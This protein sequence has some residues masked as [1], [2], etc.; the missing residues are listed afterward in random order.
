MAKLVAYRSSVVTP[1]TAEALRRL[2]LVASERGGVRIR[3]RGVSSDE[4]SWDGVQRDP[5]PT[6]LPPHLSMRPTGREVYLS[7]T[8]EEGT[9]PM[10][11][12]AILWGLAVPLGFMPWGRYPVPSLHDHVFHFLGPWAIIPDFL[13]GEG[14]GE[15]AWPSVCAAAQCHVARWGG[16]KPTEHALQAHLHRLGIHCGPVDGNVGERT[17]SSL[18]AMGLGG[19]PIDQALQALCQMGPLTP[20]KGK[21]RVGFF[22]MSGS[23]EAFPSG[24]VHVTRT[25]AGYA[26]TADGPGKITL[27][28]GE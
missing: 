3:Y 21:R 5:G 17:L 11:E 13:N 22:T 2:E 20:E 15:Q 7:V 24:Q 9:D 10:R 1:D 12:L 26:V 25:R 14:R 28:F 6:G 19:I 18:K 4:A 8:T 16:P 23:V 27:L